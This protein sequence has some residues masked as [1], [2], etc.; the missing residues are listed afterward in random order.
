MCSGVGGDF[1]DFIPINNDQLAIVVG[2]VVGHGI[3]AAMI[4]AQIMGMIRTET[5]RI[6]RP[7]Q[8]F[9]MLNSQLVSIDNKSGCYI[10]TGPGFTGKLV[11]KN[12]ACWGQVAEAARLEGGIAELGM[13]NINAPGNAGFHVSGGAL[14]TTAG[15]YIDRKVKSYCITER[16]AKATLLGR[17]GRSQ[18]EDTHSAGRPTTRGTVIRP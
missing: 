4:M 14:L 17:M 2:D 18:N 8:M 3:R 16:D 5:D 11:M 10:K 7:A 9:E 12:T 13:L 6:G 15:S 1:Y